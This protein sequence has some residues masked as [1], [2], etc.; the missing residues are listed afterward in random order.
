MKAILVKFSSD[1]K[2]GNIMY[3]ISYGIT[4]TTFVYSVL[5]YANAV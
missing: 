1:R 5:K 3:V 2:V 4:I